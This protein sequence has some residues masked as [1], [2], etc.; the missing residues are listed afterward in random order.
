VVHW[1]TKTQRFWNWLGAIPHWLYFIDLRS[2]AALWSQVVIWTSILGTFLTLTGLYVGVAQFPWGFGREG[3]PYRGAF[4]WHHMT[5]LMFGLVTLTWV[6]SGL[7]SMNPWGFLESGRGA[8]E[9]ARIEG[10]PIKWVEVRASLDVLRT[11]PAIADAANLTTA[12]LEGR[13][14]W[15]ATQI[16]GSV[17][18]LDATGNVASAS[19]TDL[20]RAAQRLAE[21]AGIA[22]QGMLYEEDAYYFRKRD[23]FVLPVY[24][25]IL[26]DKGGTRYYLDPTTG[27]LLLRA[28]TNNRWHRWLFGGLHRVDFMPWLRASP[29]WDVVVLILMLGGLALTST[30]LYLAMR[31]V[32]KDVLALF[33]LA[34][35]RGDRE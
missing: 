23:S 8:D 19:K 26:S 31:R 17:I 18:R 21:P 2:N 25:V 1:T 33:R 3:S 11:R 22:E 14:Y 10:Q 20:A 29:V 4:Y 15:R 35:R 16:D 9:Q 28:D 32:C 5:G 13:L 12:S 7:I 30:G 24:R 27:S 6:L 34:A